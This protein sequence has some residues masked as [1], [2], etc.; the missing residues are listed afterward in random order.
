MTMIRITSVADPL[1]RPGILSAAMG[2][3]RRAVGAGLLSERASIDTLDLDLIHNIAR[4][5]SRAGVGSDAAV[6]LLERT[7]DDHLGQLLTRLDAALTDSPMPERELAELLR[8]YDYGQLASLVGTSVASLRRYAAGTR[9][10]PDAIAER[11]HYVALVTSDLAGSYNEFGLRRWWDRSRA[12]LGDRSPRQALGR[13]W[14]AD[15]PAAGTVAELA[16]SLVG[17]ATGS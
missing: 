9:N 13:D 3:V 6:A 11:L 12:L 2:V 5:A 17:N 4:G 16:T 8:V 7:N 15:D 1:N 14:S 10:V